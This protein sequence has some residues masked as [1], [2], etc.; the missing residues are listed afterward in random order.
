MEVA[1]G[2]GQPGPG[3][4]SRPRRPMRRKAD[5]G[6]AQAG[7]PLGVL[8]P[9]AVRGARGGCRRRQGRWRASFVRFRF[10]PPASG[11]KTSGTGLSIEGLAP[12]IGRFEEKRRAGARA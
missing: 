1:E 7:L 3:A 12:S 4:R 10:A 9:G 8:P 11:E 2:E 6:S 5:A